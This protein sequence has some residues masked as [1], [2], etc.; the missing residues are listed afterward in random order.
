[1]KNKG[2][3]LAT[4]FLMLFAV[5]IAYAQESPAKTTDIVQQ[6]KETAQQGGE[7]TK[8]IESEAKQVHNLTNETPGT[9]QIS[10]VAKQVEQKSGEAGT[11]VKKAEDAAMKAEE[12]AKSVP[13]FDVC[14]GILGFLAVASISLGRR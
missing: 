5:T 9:A 1:M 11:A 7:V 6:L 3:I 13:G 12:T 4:A 2:V 14:I 10:E 8:Q